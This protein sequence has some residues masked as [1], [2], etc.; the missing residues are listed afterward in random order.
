[1]QVSAFPETANGKLDRKA[2][3][4]P[5]D[6]DLCEDTHSAELNPAEDDNDCEESEIDRAEEEAKRE[7]ALSMGL[8]RVKC[9]MQGMVYDEQKAAKAAMAKHILD[10]VE[11][12]SALSIMF[13]SSSTR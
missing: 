6:S 8:K 7:V 1:M 3:R 12:V 11:K 10:M 9:D 2:L 13:S 4:D 5:I